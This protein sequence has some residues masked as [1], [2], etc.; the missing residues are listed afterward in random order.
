MNS[1]TAGLQIFAARAANVGFVTSHSTNGR[2]LMADGDF[3]S[4]PLPGLPRW[5]F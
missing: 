2:F 5:H 3:I 1:R 4:P